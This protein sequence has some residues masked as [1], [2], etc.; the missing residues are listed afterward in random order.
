MI[1][2]QS[3]IVDII[4]EY[5]RQLRPIFCVSEGDKNTRMINIT[6][7]QA[8]ENF[9][10]PTSATVYITGKK[11]DNTIFSYRCSFSGYIVSFQIAEQ[12]SAKDGIVLCEL[13]IIDGGNP[14]G[15]ANF[16]YW[17]EPSPVANG[18]A[19]ESDLNVFLEAIV[20]AGKLDNFYANVED[21]VAMAVENIQIREGQTVIDASL[22]VEGAAADA[23]ATGDIVRAF[24]DALVSETTAE[25]AVATCDDAAG[26]L[27]LKQFV[28]YIQPT[29][30]GT[31]DPSPDNVRPISGYTGVTVTRTG[32]N[33]IDPAG[34]VRENVFSANADGSYTFTKTAQSSSGRVTNICDCLVKA[35]Q[36]VT[37]SADITGEPTSGNPIYFDLTATTTGSVRGSVICTVSGGKIIG[38]VAPTEDTIGARLHYQNNSTGVGDSV[39]LRNIQVECGETATEYAGEAEVDTYSVT[40]PTAAGTVY[41]GT[42]TV[43]SDGSGTL[44]VDRAITTYADHTWTVNASGVAVASGSTPAAKDMG[45]TPGKSKFDA[46]CSMLPNVG[47]STVANMPDVSMAQYGTTFRVK[48]LSCATANDYL[49]KYSAAQI[50]YTIAQPTTYALSAVDVVQMLQGV[51]NIWTDAAGTLTT[52]YYASTGLYV[53]KKVNAQRNMIAG[54]EDAMVA[55]QNYSVGDLLIVGNTLYK[56]TAAV[57]SGAALV[58]G[59]NVTETT[60]A[61]QLLALA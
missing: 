58:V 48:D 12:M 14:L 39:V 16:V 55:T 21:M 57:S 10:I 46:V 40:F 1:I 15:S 22:S 30:S 53:E 42:L 51:N 11:A 29:Q 8:G 27:P 28:G 4:P 26:G 24:L 25:A 6:V 9:S 61:E 50:C 23:K 38:T 35:G 2:S 3:G 60:V 41:G 5:N 56:V 7:Q 37:F 47:V 52:E 17:V 32:K 43:N 44:T 13:Q 31:G 36:T 34:M 19:S 59:T 49:T 33:L 54:V 20:G 45:S 18:D